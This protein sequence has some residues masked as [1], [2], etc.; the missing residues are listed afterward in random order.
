[1]APEQ[2]LR[3]S[4]GEIGVL[5]V[6]SL[7]GLAGAFAKVTL[8]GVLPTTSLLGRVLVVVDLEESGP[9]AAA[10]VN[11]PALFG[12]VVRFDQAT[13]IDQKT[14]GKRVKPLVLWQSYGIGARRREEWLGA[15]NRR[16]GGDL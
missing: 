8:D 10:R 15:I 16:V 11:R 2:M 1:M 5:V 12:K 9:A 6:V 3:L 13:L 14:G 7:V 4:A